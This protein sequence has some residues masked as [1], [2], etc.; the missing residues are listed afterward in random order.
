MQISIN[1]W[2]APTLQLDMA[3][4]LADEVVATMQPLLEE[5]TG[6]SSEWWI[7]AR[8]VLRVRL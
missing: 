5:W 7:A 2:V 6:A 1:T 8:S 4:A 3:K